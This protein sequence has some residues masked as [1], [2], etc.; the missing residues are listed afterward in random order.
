MFQ[1]ER[2]DAK[3]KRFRGCIR[4]IKGR[5]VWQADGC[6]VCKGCDKECVFCKGENRIVMNQCIKA[7]KIDVTLMPYFFAFMN[8][9]CIAYPDGRGRLYQPVKLTQAFDII[10]FYHQKITE[11]ESKE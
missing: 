3:V 5:K 6:F 11:K 9:N 10:G 4:P 2:C 8:S 1:C 7:M